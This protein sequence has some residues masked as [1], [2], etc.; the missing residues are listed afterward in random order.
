MEDDTTRIH[1][2]P[3]G[4]PPTD[5]MRWISASSSHVGKVRKLNEDALLD[6]PQIGL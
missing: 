4:A 2:D 1:A 3:N 5:A 6:Y